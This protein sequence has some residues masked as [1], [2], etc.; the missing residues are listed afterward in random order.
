MQLRPEKTRWFETYVR[1]EESVMVLD[2]LAKTGMVELEA[3]PRPEARSLDSATIHRTIHQFLALQRDYAPLMPAPMGESQSAAKLPRE[4]ADESLT[5][6]SEWCAQ[7][8][9]FSQQRARLEKERENLLLLREYLRACQPTCANLRQLGQR[10]SSLY[11]RLFA[12]PRDGDF[13]AK[14]DHAVRRQC[15]ADSQDFYIVLDRLENRSKIDTVF[16]HEQCQALD[17]PAWLPA[18]AGAQK[19]RIMMRLQEIDST[20]KQTSR[21]LAFGKDNRLLASASANIALLQWYAQHVETFASDGALC[22]VAG[23]TTAADSAPLQNA[24]DQINSHAIVRFAAPPEGAK[25]PV[26]LSPSAW[27]KPFQFFIDV[28]GAPDSMEVDPSGLLPF[29]VPVLFGY[30]FPDVGHGLILALCSALAYRFWPQG[31]FLFVCGLSAAFFG[32]LFGEVFGY[33]HFM[34]ALWIRPL[35]NPLAVLL[36]P[37][38]FGAGILLLGLGLT[39]L[40]SHW[41]RDAPVWLMP[42]AAVFLLYATLLGA[43]AE[44]KALWLAALALPWYGLSCWHAAAAGRRLGDLIKSLG[45]LAHSVFTLTLNTLSFLRVGAF[46][47]AHAGLSSVILQ[48]AAGIEDFFLRTLLLVCGHLLIVA[49]E[50]LLAFVQTTRLV[51]LEFFVHFLRIEGRLFRPLAAA[52]RRLR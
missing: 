34:P 3:P 7:V 8:E 30:M 51:L 23:W 38:L 25:P 28:F 37:L 32:M 46:A 26:T 21:H 16:Q 17:I 24:L 45:L 49:V 4:L 15:R 6:V 31:R 20:L 47:L 35:D 11:K 18:D 27:V 29:I 39:V 10:G 13:A 42:E 22:H 44:P 19:V 41:R 2:A 14:L 33:H 36:A 12:C 5:C 1:R 52:E 43:I 9:N 48:L 50:G 40:E